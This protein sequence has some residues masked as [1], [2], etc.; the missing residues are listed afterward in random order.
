MKR[1]N[2]IW[3]CVLVLLWSSLAIGA[4]P[5]HAESGL[6]KSLASVEVDYQTW[7]DVNRLLMFVTNN[8]SFAYDNGAMFGKAD[9]LYFPR[10]TNLS[11]IYAGGLWLGGKVGG[12]LRV[13]LA[14]YSHTYT[15]GPMLNGTFQEDRD[16]FKVYK[17]DKNLRKSGFYDGPRPVGAVFEVDE[18]DPAEL[19]DDYHNW[20]EDMGAP[21]EDVWVLNEDG[22][23]STFVHRPKIT[24]DQ[25][26]WC[27]YNDA[28]P[29]DHVNSAG[30]AEGLGVEVQQTTFAFNRTG[31]LG[32]C[33]FI[34]YVFINKSADTIKEMY[35]SVWA[36]PDLGDASDDFVGCDTDLSL[37]YCYNAT[38]ND[39]NYGSTPPATG[40]DFFQG[41]IVETGEETDSVFFMGAWR[42]GVQALPMTSFAKYI[43]GTDPDNANETYWYMQGLDAKNSGAPF[44]DPTTGQETRYMLAGDPV[45]GTGWVDDNAADRRY[46]QSAGPFDMAPNDTQQVVVAV[47]VGQGSDRLTSVTALKFN[48]LFAQSAF[49][50]QFD[51]A[52]PPTRP[53]VTAVPMDGGIALHWSTISEDQPG[54]YEFQGYNV[55]QGESVAGPWKRIATFDIDD[56][57]GI[58]FDME[59]VVEEGVVID[60]PVQFGTDSGIRRFI[61]ITQDAWRG[62]ALHNVFDYYWSVTAYSYDPEK[63]PKTL[64]N[65]PEAITVAPQKPAGGY[66]YPLDYAEILEVTHDAGASDGSVEP[67][68]I[69]PR[70]LT[71]HSYR[72][73]FTEDEG[74]NVLWHLYD[75]TADAWVLQDQT[76]QTGDDDYPIV[77]GFQIKVAG[78]PQGVNTVYEVA[79]AGGAVVD[80]PDNVF[81]SWNSTHDFYTSSDQGSN[82]DRLNW[83][84]HI[85]T[86]DWELRFTAGGSEYYDWISEETFGDRAPFEVWNIGS[87]TPDD[88][89]D[90]VRIQFAIID[91]D[92]SGGYST[93]DR[94]YPFEREYF[95][96][97]PQYMEYTWDDDFKIGRIVINAGDPAEGTVIRYTTNK[98]NATND[99]YSFDAPAVIEEDLAADATYDMES[100]RVV[101]NPYF[102]QSLYEPDQFDRR[103]KFTNLPYECEIKVFNLAGDHIVT[104]NKEASDESFLTWD[105]LTEHELPLASGV[106]I[107]LVTAPDGTEHIGKMA[108]FTEVEQLNTY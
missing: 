98:V 103:V 31:S 10:G 75:V 15:P 27:V 25:T 17:I 57:T 63:T 28:S 47:L 54:D 101:P 20:P 64:E 32:E 11:V 82:I 77:D 104:L 51:L 55:Y 48:D 52:D 16:E 65:A 37:G 5:R 6:Y 87:A 12:D 74:G 67:V 100:I 34:D 56:G 29:D 102:N 81:W 92:E 85:G 90:D 23:D 94:I 86:D 41:P 91:D 44:I 105:M 106:Y 43:N 107:Y 36:D 76:N 88:A 71:G 8:G 1:T 78:P 24:G 26:L 39:A 66:E 61:E 69:D 60:H 22:T 80:P 49:D 19:W 72:V 93:G 99:I 13:S 45:T 7:I 73:T 97:L 14:E 53:Q 40:Y 84:G 70:A 30:S 38:N 2:W 4:P 108:I 59:F 3:C 62:G 89:S 96:G 58:I 79:G 83:R 68:V 21:M 18:S 35:V 42:Y 33:V 50:A 9:G 95:E 46:M